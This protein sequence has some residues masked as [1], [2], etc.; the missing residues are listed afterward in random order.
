[1]TTMICWGW[2]RLLALCLALGCAAAEAETSTLLVYLCGT[3]LQ[4]AGC[5]DMAEM[6]E[7]DAGE[8]VNVVVLAGGAKE[9]EYDFL[10]GNTRTLVEIR[11]G[12]A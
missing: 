8:N 10:E 9:W 1:M 11:D 5:L 12:D 3:D 2:I 6:A 7:A 4:D